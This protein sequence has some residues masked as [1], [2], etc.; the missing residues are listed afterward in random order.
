ML[1]VETSSTTT[2]TTA[3]TTSIITDDEPLEARSFHSSD[4]ELSGSRPYLTRT[5]FSHGNCM[6]V[7]AA[8]IESE[9]KHLYEIEISEKWYSHRTHLGTNC[10][11]LILPGI[12]F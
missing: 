1:K 11:C 6:H 5:A 7:I 4:G 3:A 8:A 10:Q 2:T 12:P 9:S